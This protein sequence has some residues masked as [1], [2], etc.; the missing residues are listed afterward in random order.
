MAEQ[1]NIKV[2]ATNRKAFHDY[3]ILERFEAGIV[4]AGTEVKSLRAGKASLVD[5]YAGV[6]KGEA[7]IYNLFI[8][9]YDKGNRYNKPERRPRKLLLHKQEITRLLGTVSQKGFTV[10]PLQLYFLGSHVKVELGVAKGK[11]EFDKREDLKERESKREI[12]RAYKDHRAD[13]RSERRTE[14]KPDRD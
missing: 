12:D 11:R 2:I 7:F 14:R 5:S 3:H 1:K 8:N 6:T 10:V 9:P 4:L 13:R